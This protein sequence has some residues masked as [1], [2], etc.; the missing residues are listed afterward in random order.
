L[1]CTLI[2][3]PPG[4][5]KTTRILELYRQ[6]PNRAWILT[7]TATMAEHLANELA[8]SGVAVRP[9]RILT[10]SRFAEPYTAAQSPSDARMVAL[11][12]AALH[13]IKPAVFA[14]VARY[15]GFHSTLASL[16]SELGSGGSPSRRLAQLPDETHQ[17]LAAI[18]RWI[19]QRLAT[20]GF[21]LRADRLQ[22]A[23]QRLATQA[24]DET[25]LID[26]FFEF[27]DPELALIRALAE[28]GT[29]VATLPAAHPFFESTEHLTETH[30]RPARTLFA[31]PTLG[32]EANEIARRI[33]LE[34]EHRPWRE[35]GVVVRSRDPYVAALETA[36][37][38][39]GIPSRSY[40]VAPLATQPAIRFLS[41]IV[42]A[43]LTNWEW[44]SLL[45]WLDLP[46]GP[47]ARHAESTALDFKLRQEMPGRGLE[48]LAEIFPAEIA[49]IQ[50]QLAA[51]RRTPAE[52]IER[53]AALLDLI[54]APTTAE[55]FK[56]TQPALLS[57][58]DALK[59]A[60]SLLG[61]REVD[62]ET[63]WREINRVL[64][65]TPFRQRDTRRDVVHILDVFE[66]R[67]WELPVVFVCGLNERLF[68]QYHPQD[69]LLDNRARTILGLPTSDEKEQN[70]R[71]LFDVASTRATQKLILSY[72][73]F[74]QK[75][76]DQLRSFFLGDLR[77][78]EC[79]HRVTVA[80]PTRSA[81]PAFAIIDPALLTHLAE[82]HTALSPSA[83]EEYLQC[84]HQ[85]F[86]R[87]TLRLQGRPDRPE[88]RLNFLVQGNIMHR[89]LESADQPL[90]LF[91]AFETA[92][93]QACRDAHIPQTY[94]REA[95]RLEM[96][97]N[98]EIFRRT[99]VTLGWRTETEK[100]FDFKLESGLRIRGRIDR[101]EI[102][103]KKEAVVIDFK[104]SAQVAARAENV[105]A[106][107]PGLYL[108]AA[109]SQFGLKPFGTLY[110]GV[111]N[112]VNW[113][114][115]HLS[116]AGLAEIGEAV[117]LVTLREKMTTAAELADRAYQGILSGRILPLPADDSKCAWCDFRDSCRI[118]IAEPETQ[119]E[120]AG[121]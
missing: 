63:A 54:P 76:E 52:W 35:I 69:P 1:R 94:R 5:G 88:E 114:G 103:P 55:E 110:C 108:L 106:V 96:L 34:A 25:Y 104:Y 7:P 11:A 68:P 64:S 97:R 92:F 48:P 83:I 95:I 41:A 90:F 33:L 49:L 85:F 81:P 16:V 121:S 80:A 46:A 32:M 18:A 26:G 15:P 22:S 71:F 105:N 37:A 93:E 65:L 84:P 28:R 67:Q 45:P 27:A 12:E 2:A 115:W 57:F 98:L 113:A 10:L 119:V 3:G 75:G 79:D 107:Q 20:D 82:R 116:H 117:D 66:A 17:A 19:E 86:S 51:A 112:G 30:R 100:Q 6:D 31:S 101:L 14:R 72:S 13:A 53:I 36:F 89:A 24:P 50:T 59:E 56:R 102:S 8:R 73:R 62:L 70:E 44:D 9:N 74:N 77:A 47:F 99:I 91:S 120:K 40:F 43:A 39:F 58:L 38:R 61:T 109:E 60:A 4:S 23:A 78:E 21:A 42:N 87:R 111:K 118:E 29:V